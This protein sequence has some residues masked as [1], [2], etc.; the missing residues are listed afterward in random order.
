[1]WKYV[2][3]Y[4]FEEKKRMIEDFTGL[5]QYL[6]LSHRREIERRN[7]LDT[8]FIVSNRAS[9]HSKGWKQFKSEV[10][11][12][13]QMVCRLSKKIR[14]EKPCA[15]HYGTRENSKPIE[16]SL[17]RNSRIVTMQWSVFSMPLPIIK[18]EIVI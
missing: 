9:L 15:G 13:N 12:T 2:H 4:L 10:T 1:M 8:F 5:Q 17:A 7:E 11:Q 3:I 18:S 16:L 14:K 6:I